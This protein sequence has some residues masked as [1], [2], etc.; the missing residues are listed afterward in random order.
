MN[1]LIKELNKAG[2]PQKAKL[3]LRF[4]KTGKGEYAQGDVF[5]GIRNPQVREIVKKYYSLP[6]NKLQKILNSKIHEHRF[7]VLVILNRQIELAIRKKDK[8][9]IEK[10]SSFYLKNTSQI[11][12]WDLVD[13]SCPNILGAHILFDES[14]IKMLYELSKSSDLWEKR[15]SVVSTLKLVRAGK[16]KDAIQLCKIH[17]YEKHDLMQKAVGWVLRE[18]GKKDKKILIEFLEKYAKSMPRTALRYSLEKLNP[19][20]KKKYMKK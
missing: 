10:I 15:I 4:F 2:D 5:I 20:E 18:V 11:N 1:D 6:L 8:K 16:L 14:K 17:L 13:I 12:N 3:A 9:E 19:K 7:A